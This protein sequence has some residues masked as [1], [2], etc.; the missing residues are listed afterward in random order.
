MKV[1]KNICNF[2]VLICVFLFCQLNHTLAA[3]D[4]INVPVWTYYTSAPFITGKNS[5]LSY[6][7][8]K[9]LNKYTKGK[10]VF[11]LEILPRTR[12]NRNLKNNIKGIVLFVNWSWMQDPDKSKYIW[13]ESI[14][15]DQNE[16]LSRK[17]G[18]NPTKIIFTN[19][20][21]L[22]GNIFGGVRGHRYKNLEA[23]FENG[24]VIRKDV[25]SVGQNLE[26]LL[27]ERIDFTTSNA[28]VV[29]YAIKHKNLEDKIFL[30]PRPLFSY[31]RHLLITKNLKEIESDINLFVNSLNSNTEWGE[32]MD[33]YAVYK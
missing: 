32:I 18:K 22:K 15:S 33:F 1:K 12:I 3:A 4:E 13:S 9:I 31:T 10:Y 24:D 28:S 29:R 20:S 16:I 26:L 19:V 27:R 8:I 23:S 6:D 21:A 7:F 25:R 5:G 17:D 2:K 14:L 30:S 11:S